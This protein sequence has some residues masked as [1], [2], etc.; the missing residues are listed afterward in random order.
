MYSF[1]ELSG[2]PF[3]YGHTTDN[4][5]AKIDILCIR[6]RLVEE[7][8]YPRRDKLAFSQSKSHGVVVEIFDPRT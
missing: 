5:H 8:L 3:T 6:L 1:D 7:K 2:G 4:L